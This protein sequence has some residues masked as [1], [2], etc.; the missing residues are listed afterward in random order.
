MDTSLILWPGHVL[1]IVKILFFHV[2]F[3]ILIANTQMD[4]QN[5]FKQKTF[6]SLRKAMAVA[7]AYAQ[8]MLDEGRVPDWLV[9]I[10]IR[11]KLASS[12]ALRKPL[13]QVAQWI[14]WASLHVDSTMRNPRPD[15]IKGAKDP[16]RRGFWLRSIYATLQ[17]ANKK[18]NISLR[19]RKAGFFETVVSNE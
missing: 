1:H 9:R 11:M 18:N 7:F 15:F 10:G 3:S 14:L 4:L 17:N 19:I 5:E 12:S 13:T 6:N 16:W 8:R 2:R